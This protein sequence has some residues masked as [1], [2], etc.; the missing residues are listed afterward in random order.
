[1]HR[2]RFL[3]TVG[4]LSALSLAGCQTSDDAG[5][6]NESTIDGSAT[7]T[8]PPTTSAPA[9]GKPDGIYVQ[10][11]Q[12]R[13]SMQGMAEAGD[14][15]FALMFTVPH[16]FW[17]VTGNT[18]SKV[19]R[20]PEDSIHQMASTWD[21]ET[22]TALPETGL[23]VEINRDG[24]LV[25][26]EVIYPMLSQPMGFHYG[27]NFT[28]DGDGTYTVELSVGA[29]NTRRAGAFADRLNE[30]A[31]AEIDLAFTDESRSE[32]SSQPID[33]GGQPGALRPMEMMSTPK[34]TAP[35]REEVPGSV[36]G[37]ARSDDA[38]FL[39]TVLDR[40]PAGVDGNG[41]YLA[42]S[43]RTRYNG[44]ELPAMALSGTVTRGSETLF[45]GPLTRTIHPELGYHYG[46]P[47]ESVQSGDELALSVETIPQV[48]RHEGYET[49]F[50]QF[51]DVT[52]TL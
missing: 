32:V 25:T 5:S 48:A 42:V 1:M 46:A 12:E 39:V 36:R 52:V 35:S 30:P 49:A 43:A 22:R 13:M 33:Q 28:L 2:R 7:S 38:D 50:R 4:T 34:A 16:T 26:E 8:A 29:T 24:S 6:G 23:S 11:F 18:V 14:Y 41:Q 40:P 17:T 3:A 20:A 31:S 45:D 10:T 47:V 51:E 37:S 15:G 27:G 9:S 21:A 44:Y 19:E